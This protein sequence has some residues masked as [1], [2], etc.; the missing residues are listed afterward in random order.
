M[1]TFNPDPNAPTPSQMRLLALAAVFQSAGLVFSLASQGIAA[2][3]SHQE[4]FDALYRLALSNESD[5]LLRLGSIDRYTLGLKILEAVLVPPISNRPTPRQLQLS[6]PRRYAV[7]L[8]ATERR[9]YGKAALVNLTHQQLKLL[10]QRAAF[11]NQHYRHPS[12]LAGMAGTYLATAGTLRS[13]I[14]VKGQKNT[15]TDSATVDAIRATLFAGV[16]AAHLWRE[17][18]GH[19]LQ[20]LFQKRSMLA[21]LRAL[22]A[23]R[24][25]L[26][27]HS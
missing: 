25:Q 21:D 20:L 11:F 19:R 3:Q 12:M 1:T 7:A 2:Q 10:N 18:G 17:L 16:Q 27:H 23:K 9:I 22:A 24:Y 4:A 15:L 26:R 6:E 13:R 5:P 8:M 14:K